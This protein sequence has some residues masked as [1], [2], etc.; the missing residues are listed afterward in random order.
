[1]AC[2]GGER[3][4]E[5]AMTRLER[6]VSL[7]TE[8]KFLADLLDLLS[9]QT[10]D[11]APPA[12]KT[13]AEQALSFRVT[14]RMGCCVYQL[15]TI[16]TETFPLRLFKTLWDPDELE[17]LVAPRSFLLDSWSQRFLKTFG[18]DAA[19]RMPRYVYRQLQRPAPAKQSRSGAAAVCTG[20]SQQP[21]NSVA[22]RVHQLSL[23]VAEACPITG[24]SQTRS[25][26]AR[27]KL[28]APKG[29]PSK[30]YRKRSKL[31]VNF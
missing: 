8:H 10:W 1:M 31:L 17:L 18:G 29:H 7:K 2:A 28:E 27:L 9:L 6:Y 23:G 4:E 16:S 26:Q 20:S 11:C 30:R 25:D 21:S 19:L 5:S 15:L 24:T 3:Q 13:L 14:S 22:S 12:N